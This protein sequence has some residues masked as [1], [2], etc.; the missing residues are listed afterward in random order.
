M[1]VRVVEPG[2]IEV[3]YESA[4]DMAPARQGALRAL[5][6]T[7]LAHGPLALVFVVRQVPGVDAAVPKYWL[8]VT[9]RLAPRLC[10]MAVTSTSMAVRA[11][12]RAFSVA[13]TLTRVAVDARAFRDEIEALDWARA[14]VRAAASGVLPATSA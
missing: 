2:I 9:R 11:A 7:Q 5:M 8:E 14:C 12:A 13:N 4:D 1:S 3:V 6:D 10:A